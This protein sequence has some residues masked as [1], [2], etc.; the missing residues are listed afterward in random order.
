MGNTPSV[1]APRKGSKAAQKL[2]KPRIGNPA[3]A[4]L[5]N[6]SGVSDIIRRPPSTTG[7]RLSLPYSSTPIPSPRHPET[8][9]TTLDD[10]AVLYGASAPVDDYSHPLFRPDPQALHQANQGVGVLA[11]SSRSRSTSKA[12]S[13]YM[14]TGEGYEEAQL[15]LVVS[16]RNYDLA[17]Y[18][19]NRL[20]NLIEDPPFEDQSMIT[21]SQLPIALSRQQSYTASYHPAHPDAGTLLPRTNSDA[22]LYTPMRRRSLMTPGVATRPILADLIIPPEIQTSDSLT[23]PSHSPDSMEVGLLPIPHPPFDPS[24]APRA[25]TPCETEYQQTGGFKHGTLRI[26]NGSPVITPAR[27]TADANL[28]AKSSTTTIRQRSYIG[29]GNPAREK[30]IGDSSNGQ[31]PVSPDATATP[32]IAL[33]SYLATAESDREFGLN[34]LPELELELTLS[35]FSISGI[36]PKSPELQTTSKHTAIEDELFDDGLAEYGTEALDVCLDD[37]DASPHLSSD[38]P[39]EDGKQKGIS[40]SDSGIVASPTTSA[41]YKPLSKADS[42]YSSSVSIRS[43]TSKRNGQQESGRAQNTE[44][45]SPQA[46]NVKQLGKT[47]AEDNSTTLGSLDVQMQAPSLDGPPPPVPEKD[48]LLKAPKSGDLLHNDPRLRASVTRGS[49]ED[50]NDF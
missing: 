24:L 7:R 35:P 41:S 2:S 19:T 34:F 5:L 12:D 39:L 44:P 46:P 47:L 6:P 13:A 22:S 1:E 37:D 42:G 29:D 32:S 14:G 17:S 43:F 3:T 36:E 49:Q 28:H 50:Y 23:P 31:R 11:S 26:T 10:L 15:D 30:Q 48:H 21:E 16:P 4:G 45:V 20:L 40:R 8:E 18:E 9:Q 33:P 27:E 38:A 25:H